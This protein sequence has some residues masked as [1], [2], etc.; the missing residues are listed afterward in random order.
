MTEPTDARRWAQRLRDYAPASSVLS[1]VMGQAAIH[2]DG[3][4]QRIEQL[5]KRLA[6]AA[7]IIEVA[8]N[9]ALAADGPVSHCRDEMTDAEWRRLYRAVKREQSKPKKNPARG[10]ASQLTPR[11]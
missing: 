7:E 3:A 4:A 5:E 11:R 6:D 2:L 8:D 10:G 9:R 1:D